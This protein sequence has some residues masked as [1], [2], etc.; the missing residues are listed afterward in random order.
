MR[1]LQDFNNWRKHL[2]EHFK[3]KIGLTILIAI[4]AISCVWI[5][6]ATATPG[7]QNSASFVVAKREPLDETRLRRPV[8]AATTTTSTTTTTTVPKRDE[9]VH[10]PKPPVAS[11]IVPGEDIWAKLRNCEAGGDYL[12]NTGNGYYGAYQFSAP[13][14]RSMGTGYAF[15]HEAPPAVQDDAA[16]RLQA[17][18][19]WGQWPACSIKIGVR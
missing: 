13:T 6:R 2:P 4:I 7:S 16:L 1:I 3:R 14:W 10:S 12:K 5:G 9:A 8:L 17:R 15:A 18:S 19:D 11:V